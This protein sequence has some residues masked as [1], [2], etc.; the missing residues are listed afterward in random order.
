[1]PLSGDVAVERRPR[2]A[3]EGGGRV[4]ASGAGASVPGADLHRR[5][6]PPPDGRRHRLGLAGQSGGGMGDH[7]G[8]GRQPARRRRGHLRRRPG[9]GSEVQ[10]HPHRRGT[11]HPVQDGVVEPGHHRR[12][13]T[14]QLLYDQHLPQRPANVQRAAQ[15]VADEPVQLRR[16]PRRRDR[17]PSDVPVQVEV[18]VVHPHRPL[19]VQGEAQ[20]PLAQ[21]RDQ[22]EAGR[23]HR[24]DLGV[25][26][27]GGE[28]RPGALGRVEHHGRRHVEPVGVGLE[29][30]EGAVEPGEGFQRRRPGPVSARC[31]RNRRRPVGPRAGRP[32]R[33]PARTRP[34]RPPGSPAGRCGPRGGRRRRARGRC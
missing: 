31:A 29:R 26:G 10:E 5:I 14:G 22:V 34:V 15:E 1:M 6:E 11:R 30:Q 13:A 19:Q 21:P 24:A 7:L 2:G 16:A 28:Q 33:P 8:G 9:A 3:E 17:R 4:L 27:G 18:G 25:A 32:A 12:S 20:R 23:H